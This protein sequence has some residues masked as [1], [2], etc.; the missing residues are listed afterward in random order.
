MNDPVSIAN[1][2]GGARVADTRHFFKNRNHADDTIVNLAAGADADMVG[3][4]S[5]LTATRIAS[6]LNYVLRVPRG[7]I[8]LV[9][10]WNVPLLM[11]TWKIAPAL[12][13]GN[14]VVLKPS[15]LTPTT[16]P[17]LYPR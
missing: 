13:C 8:A 4:E 7:V 1:F 16:A 12:A 15:E 6:A 2:I 9:F 5:Y 3:A 14:T 10:P 11:A 17:L